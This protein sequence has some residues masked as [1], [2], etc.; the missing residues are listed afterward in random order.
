[1]VTNEVVG[2]PDPFMV[3]RAQHER[4]V[5]PF[6]LSLSKGVGKVHDPH[7]WINTTYYLRTLPPDSSN[8]VSRWPGPRPER[9]EGSG[10]WPR[11]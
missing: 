10:R 4:E 8:V 6:A 11:S 5:T 7:M 1:M 3:R 2:R 9:L